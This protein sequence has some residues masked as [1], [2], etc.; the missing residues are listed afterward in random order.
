MSNII[1]ISGTPCTG[2]TT[3]SEKLSEKLNY[4][5][6]KVNDLAIDNN[7]V[8]GIDDDKGYKII[9]I[10]GLNDL[11]LEIISEHDN[12]I[13]EGHLS[14]LCSGADKLIVLRCRP[15]I[16]EKRLAL[17]DYSDAKI[18]ENL[19]AEAMG[20]CSAESLDIYDNNVYELDVSDLSVDDAVLTLIDVV[21]GEKE[22][23]FG[24]ID[25]MDWL[26]VHQ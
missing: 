21:N 25:F 6:I 12:L 14:H 5:L 23:S 20:V 24:E 11:L 19:E 3:V 7:L 15:E 1:F 18:H 26:L 22:L 17:R 13:V 16:L 2:K 9:D 4:D 10:D 8:L